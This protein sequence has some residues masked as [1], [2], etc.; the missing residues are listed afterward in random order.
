MSIVAVDAIINIKT[1][2]FSVV[3]QREID[4]ARTARSCF[5]M[6]MS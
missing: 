5:F 1:N 3:F 4:V 2:F 6:K